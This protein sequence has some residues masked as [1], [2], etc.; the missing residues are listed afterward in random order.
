MLAAAHTQLLHSASNSR[1]D[2]SLLLLP[3]TCPC[4]CMH[5]QLAAATPS[6]NC[7]IAPVTQKHA[8]CCVAPAHVLACVVGQQQH[9]QVEWCGVVAAAVHHLDAL[10][11]CCLVVRLN[12][13]LHPHQLACSQRCTV[14]QMKGQHTADRGWEQCGA[15]RP[16]ASP[17]PARRQHAVSAANHTQQM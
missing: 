9:A 1:K 13:A 15:P 10:G 5:G 12:H 2:P 7:C 4:A 6:Q 8:S 17:T 14:Q 11:C 16:C 3:H